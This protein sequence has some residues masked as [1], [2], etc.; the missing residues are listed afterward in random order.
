MRG[1]DQ[2]LQ[3]GDG[4]EVGPNTMDGPPTATRAGQKSFRRKDDEAVGVEEIFSA[5][6]GATRVAGCSCQLARP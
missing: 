1:D 3:A 5:N 4:A 2:R 6:R